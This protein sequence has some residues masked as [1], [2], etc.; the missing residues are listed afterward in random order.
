M[1]RQFAWLELYKGMW[2]LLTDIKSES[3]DAS[4]KW[5]DRDVAITEL[6]AEGWTISGQYPNWLSD[7]LDLGNKYQG[8]GLMRTIH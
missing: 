4:Q 7:K 2:H 3:V 8:F 6:L 1:R 5:T